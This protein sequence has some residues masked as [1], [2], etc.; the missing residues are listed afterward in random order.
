MDIC[1]GEGCVI[2]CPCLGPSNKGDNK[3][4]RLGPVPKIG[5]IK[6]YLQTHRRKTILILLSLQRR[7]LS[8]KIEAFKL[9]QI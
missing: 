9:S 6:D 8:E 7:S 2:S 3:E 5:V 1:E 4:A